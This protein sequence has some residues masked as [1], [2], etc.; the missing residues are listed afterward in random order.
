MNAGG[1]AYDGMKSSREGGGWVVEDGVMAQKGKGGNIWTKDRFG[2]YILDLEVKT[3]GNSG[4]LFRVDN[5]RSYVQTGMEMQVERKGGPGRK[6]GF[7]AV[8]DC[9]APSKEV[10]GEGWHRVTLTCKDNLITIVID[11][12]QVVEMDVNK[13]DTPRK[14]PDGSRNKFG[15]AIKDFKRDGHIGF[16]DHGALVSYRNIKIKEL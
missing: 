12:E 10:G 14:N 9:I 11:G 5:P 8:Y 13:W 4:L 6:H 2:D 3:T 16:Q 7:G 15:K 1:K